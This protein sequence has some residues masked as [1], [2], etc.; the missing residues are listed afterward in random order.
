MSLFDD[1]GVE[2]LKT[3]E[4]VIEYCKRNKV[5]ME[6]LIPQIV[7]WILEKD[8]EYSDIRFAATKINKLICKHCGESLQ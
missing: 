4:D 2:G 5:K 6:S 1:M 8:L 7:A 3:P